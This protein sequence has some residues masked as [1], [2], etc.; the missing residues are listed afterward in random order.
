VAGSRLQKATQHTDK[1]L[2]PVGDKLAICHIIELDPEDTTFVIT[3]GHKGHLVHEF[4][5][6][7]YPTRTFKF[8]VVENFDGPVR[9]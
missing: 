6:L 1:F 8:V 3:L 7:A 4:L 5:P 9:V 2:V